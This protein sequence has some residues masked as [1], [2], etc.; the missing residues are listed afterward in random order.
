MT[1]P[2]PAPAIEDRNPTNGGRKDILINAELVE[3]METLVRG[4]ATNVD[5][6]EKL[7]VSPSSFYGWL[8]TGRAVKGLES[9]A[10][11]APTEPETRALCVQFL[12]S[13]TRARAA[14]RLGL[15]NAINEAVA[16]RNAEERH[17]TTVTET[18]IHPK[19]GKV[20]KYSKTTV[21]NIV[22]GVAPDGRLALDVLSRRDK[23]NW[24]TRAEYVNVDVDAEAVRMIKA[25]EIDYESLMNQFK[26]EAL[27][28]GWF[29]QA[30]IDPFTNSEESNDGTA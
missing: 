3:A 17:E 5:V 19:T 29:E 21:T 24:S 16:I 13:Y 14:Y 7:G 12:E 4:G 15:I 27:V 1:E 2:Q 23:G 10:K 22:K 26:D 30:G 18:R 25:G 28:K 9:F 6:I 20:Y 11:N 8:S